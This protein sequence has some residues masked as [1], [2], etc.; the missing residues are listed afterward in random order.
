MV[1]YCIYFPVNYTQFCRHGKLK[2]RLSQVATYYETIV[3]TG[4]EA[5]T[6]VTRDLCGRKNSSLS[7]SQVFECK[8]CKCRI[9]R[10]INGARNI[11][12]R[13]IE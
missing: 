11:L 4:S 13:F 9:G 8:K 1:N 3:K 5:Y 12:L 2:D 7:G 6:S 10:D